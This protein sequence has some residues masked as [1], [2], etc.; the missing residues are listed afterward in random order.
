[1]STTTDIPN[2]TNYREVRSLAAR[3]VDV[4]VRPD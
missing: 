3:A 4:A 2:T 1:M